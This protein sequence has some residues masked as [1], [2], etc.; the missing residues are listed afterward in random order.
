M[1]AKLLRTSEAN[2][3]FNQKPYPEIKT[4]RNKYGYV[5]NLIFL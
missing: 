5:Y 1:F 2:F 4:F 3:S